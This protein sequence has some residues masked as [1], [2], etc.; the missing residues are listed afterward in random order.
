MSIV[1]ILRVTRHVIVLST[2]GV[3][4]YVASHPAFALSCQQVCQEAQQRCWQRCYNF[5]K[6]VQTC[7]GY[8]NDDYQNCLASCP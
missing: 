6:D 7:I 5:G 3:G 8:C 1:S 4:F 2:L